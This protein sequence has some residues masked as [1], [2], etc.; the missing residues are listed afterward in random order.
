M[1]SK[2]SLSLEKITHNIA[3]NRAERER[4]SSVSLIEHCYCTVSIKTDLY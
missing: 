3:K 1:Y 4:K 2:K